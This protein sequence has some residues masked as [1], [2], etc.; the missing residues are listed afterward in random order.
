MRGQRTDSSSRWSINYELDSI[1]RGIEEDIQRVLDQHAKWYRFLADPSRIDPVYDV[2]DYDGGR[3][4][5]EPI[6]INLVQ[7]VIQQGPQ[8]HN[9]RGF[10]TVD[11]FSFAVNAKEFTDK[12]PEVALS[13]DAFLRD[14]I[15]FMGNL[16]APTTMFPRVHI[17]KRIVLLTVQATQVKSEELINDPQFNWMVDTERVASAEFSEDAKKIVRSG[18]D[19]S[20]T[21]NRPM[22]VA[23][24]PT[25]AELPEPT[26]VYYEDDLYGPPA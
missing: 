11:N 18:T 26:P 2:G 19:A 24:Y 4:W 7:A 20:Q 17:G 14:R 13:P 9:D 12:I 25:P 15:E 5:S 3:V 8:F 21:V 1:S 23:D 10:Y 16:F 22:P 6:K